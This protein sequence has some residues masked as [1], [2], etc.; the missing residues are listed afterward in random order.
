MLCCRV[1][2]IPHV[3]CSRASENESLQNRKALN[4]AFSPGNDITK[5][6]HSPGPFLERNLNFKYMVLSFLNLFRQ[7]HKLST[8]NKSDYSCAS[9]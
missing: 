9:D 6:I 1:L 7:R 3:C 2:E 4:K 8:R 5:K